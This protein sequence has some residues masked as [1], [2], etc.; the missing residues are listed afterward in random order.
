MTTV[1]AAAHDKAHGATAALSASALTPMTGPVLADFSSR[2]PN[3][4][5]PGVLKPD[6]SAPGVDILAGVAPGLSAS[7]KAAI[8][9]GDGAANSTSAYLSG[10]SM[11]TPHVTGRRQVGADDQ[12]PLGAADR[13]DRRRGWHPA[14]GPGRRP[15]CAQRGRQSGPG[16]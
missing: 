10:T 2:G 5:D 12:H 6:L 7:Q 4:F 8:I 9:A 1:A 14:M 15:G 11:A 16:L 13:P 3:G